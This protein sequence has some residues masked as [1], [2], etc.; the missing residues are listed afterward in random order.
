MGIVSEHIDAFPFD[1][2]PRIVRHREELLLAEPLPSPKR[3]PRPLRP[4][5]AVHY[6]A[7]FVPKDFEPPAG[8]YESDHLRVERQ[9]MSGFRQPFYHRNCD[10]DELSYQVF[11]TRTLMTELGTVRLEPGDFSRIPVAVAHD[12]HA[13]TD[14]HVLFYV[15]APVEER[16]PAARASELLVPPFAGWTDGTRNLMTTECLGGPEHDTVM[17]QVDE[18]MLLEQVE[19]EAER[20]RVLRP[21]PDAEGTTWLYRSDRAWIGRTFVSASDGRTY[22][23][24]RDADEI[25]YQISGRRTLVTQLGALHLEPGDFVRVPVGIA[26][27]SIVTEPSAHVT[28]LSALAV[29]QVAE[30]TKTGRR[31]TPA[32]LEELRHG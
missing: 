25:Q 13:D 23:T 12:N 2:P 22:R 30:G 17:A 20:I 32:E 6:P 3:P 28:L 5:E 29:P 24:H 21:E 4:I 11:G 1:R 18:R 7:E 31:L 19:N 10:V 16:Y 15:P 26:F 14:I 8:V 27:T 9:S